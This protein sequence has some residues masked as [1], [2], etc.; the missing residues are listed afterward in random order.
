MPWAGTPS[1]SSPSPGLPSCWR[2]TMLGCGTWGLSWPR[3]GTWARSSTSVSSRLNARSG[4]STISPTMLSSAALSSTCPSL[5]PTLSKKLCGRTYESD[6]N[7][8]WCIKSLLSMNQLCDLLLHQSCRHVSS[9][10]IDY[11]CLHSLP[12]K[13]LCSRC[14]KQDHKK[15]K[16]SKLGGTVL[17]TKPTICL[18]ICSKH[19][20]A[21][22]RIWL[23]KTKITLMDNVCRVVWPFLNTQLRPS[24]HKLHFPE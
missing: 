15:L 10:S 19:R 23:S 18:L 22:C 3:G 24:Q 21:V 20:L 7:V 17:R 5:L 6:N 1:R 9:S 14:M 16:Q 4:M 8:H 2:S 12:I 11:F 13:S